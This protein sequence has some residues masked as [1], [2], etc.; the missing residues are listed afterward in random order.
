M[1]KYNQK[2]CKAPIFAGI[3]VTS[4][5]NM[6][7][8][9]CFAQEQK[10]TM[11]LD[12]FKKAVDILVENELYKITI[13]GGEPFLN[14][15]LLKM[16]EYVK[17]KEL[18]VSLHTN[19]SLIS[20]ESVKVLKEVLDEI[21][22]DDNI[23]ESIRCSLAG[24]VAEELILKKHGIGCSNDLKKANEKAFFLLNQNCYK[25][26]DYY[27]SEITQY[28]RQEISEYVSKIFDKRVAKFIN[29]NYRIVKKQLKKF[30]SLNNII[31]SFF[32]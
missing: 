24:L 25:N 14:V 17:S 21:E 3:R 28:N 6:K 22:T 1:K 12:N 5:C 4:Y 7:C 16:I 27:C 30:L 29:K 18:V 8:P 11:L 9:H 19:G 23:I 13:T 20:D 26:L 10:M 2:K 15:D 32:S 31:D